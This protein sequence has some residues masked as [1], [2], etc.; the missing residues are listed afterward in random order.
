MADNLLLLEAGEQVN[1]KKARILVIEDD[2]IVRESVVTFLGD[3]GFDVLEAEDGERGLEVFRAEKPDMVLTDLRMPKVDGL[4]VLKHIVSEAPD[5]P[6]VVVSGMGTV[7]DVVESLRLGAWDYLT[8]PVIDMNILAHAVRKALE[9]AE[10]LHENL[11]YQE[12]L[13]EKVVQRTDQLR[14]AYG[15][16]KAALYGTVTAVSRAIEARDPY[17]AGHERRVARVAVAIARLMGLDEM[18][19]ERIR[20]GSMIHDIGKI[21]IPAEIL[22]KPGRLSDVEFEWSRAMPRSVTKF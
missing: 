17:T 6:V 22:T 10:L 16:L 19:V 1:D 3:Q 12:R 18:Q 15:N 11:R 14:E 20:L 2:A 9:R 13:E 21:H 7:D 5:M 8:K 4:Q